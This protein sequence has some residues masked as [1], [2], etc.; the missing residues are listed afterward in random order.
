MSGFKA[1]RDI[2]TAN[3]ASCPLSSQHFIPERC[4]HRSILNETQ[5]CFSPRRKQREFCFGSRGMYGVRA[6]EACDK[7][8]FRGKS[9]AGK[10]LRG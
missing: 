2:E 4:L 7:L 6:K 10:F 3:Y 8:R 9:R 1:L 5:M